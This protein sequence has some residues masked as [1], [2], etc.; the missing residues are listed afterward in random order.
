M[1]TVIQMADQLKILAANRLG[2][3]IYATPGLAGDNLYVRTVGH[4]YA[5]S[6]H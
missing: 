3:E 2:E 1:V 5:F 6:A 4:L